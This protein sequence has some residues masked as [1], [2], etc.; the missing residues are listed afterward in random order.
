[1]IDVT[2]VSNV[3]NLIRAGDFSTVT[4]DHGLIYMLLN[5]QKQRSELI[6]KAEIDWKDVIYLTSKER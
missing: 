6:L 2:L 5:L 4:A 3:G 1:M